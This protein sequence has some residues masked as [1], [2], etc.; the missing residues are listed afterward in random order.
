MA[1]LQIK[2]IEALGPVPYSSV[3]IKVRDSEIPIDGVASGQS[4]PINT[5]IPFLGADGLIMEMY[6][7]GTWFFV[8]RKWLGNH[9]AMLNE[10]EE[11]H[12]QWSGISSQGQ[13]VYFVSYQVV[14]G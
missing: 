9:R 4:K 2:T 12:G 14:D 10:T 11:Q 13:W 8:P 1:M 3:I 7:P 6:A 5:G